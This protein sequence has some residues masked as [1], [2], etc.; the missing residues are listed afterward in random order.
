MPTEQER[1]RRGLL[2]ILLSGLALLSGWLLA[3]SLSRDASDETIR[4]R[5]T[6]GDERNRLLIAQGASTP[7]HQHTE[8]RKRDTPLWKSLVESAVAV[9]TIG[10]LI[11]NIFLLGATKESAKAAKDSIDLARKNARFEQRAWL[12]FS[13]G[14]FKYTVDQPLDT[15]YQVTNT[16]KT[17]ALNVKGM[18]VTHFIKKGD[19]PSFNYDHRTQVNMGTMLPGVRQDSTSYLLHSNVPEGLHVGPMKFSMQMYRQYSSGTG[20]L[21]VYGNLEYDSVFGAHH[22][23][24]FCQTS[25]PTVYTDQCADYNNVD[26]YEEP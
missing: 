21:I 1:E 13:F 18:V 25:G 5:V 19:I 11:V 15:P 16:G 26:R 10:L 12:G 22:W 23:V 14:N 3:K 17:P 7:Q 20:Y 6:P 9:G 24:K 4:P 2:Y 8:R